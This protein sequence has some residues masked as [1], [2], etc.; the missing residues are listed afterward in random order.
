MSRV[1]VGR[2]QLT[3]ESRGCA[4]TVA[5]TDSEFD[6]VRGLVHAAAARST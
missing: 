1:A 2:C 5:I 3:T 6:Y 4:V